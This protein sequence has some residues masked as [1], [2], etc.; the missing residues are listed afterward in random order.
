VLT[1]SQSLRV[2]HTRTDLLRPIAEAAYSI[3]GAGVVAGYLSDSQ[4]SALLRR[5]IVVPSDS[6][7][8]APPVLPVPSLEVNLREVDGRT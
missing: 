3:I 7:T 4:D 2:Q 8:P 1:A 6:A 5:V